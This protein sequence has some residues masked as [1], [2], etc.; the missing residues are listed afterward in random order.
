MRLRLRLEQPLLLEM[1]TLAMSLLEILLLDMFPQFSRIQIRVGM[2][3]LDICGAMVPEKK[4]HFIKPMSQL[5]G[6]FIRSS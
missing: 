3:F 5:K 2:C 6:S 1:L 4:S